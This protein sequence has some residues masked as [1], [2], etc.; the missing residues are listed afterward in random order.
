ML[1]GLTKSAK[2]KSQLNKIFGIEE[3]F[4]IPSFDAETIP[5]GFTPKKTIENKK[6]N[7]E[8]RNSKFILRSDA[9]QDLVFKQIIPMTLIKDSYQNYFVIER[10]EPIKDTRVKGTLSLLIGGHISPVDGYA[11]NFEKC[12]NRHL[13]HDTTFKSLPYYGRSFYGYVKDDKSDLADHI[14]YIY[15]TTVTNC[16]K[17]FLSAKAAAGLTGSWMS[18]EQLMNY[19]DHFDSWCRLI[20]SHLVFGERKDNYLWRAQPQ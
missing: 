15:F 12:L 3:V 19:Y 1:N 4:V 6:I 7:L 13:K 14:G 16:Y 5:N 18:K 20:I 10:E 9:E 2:L 17:S 8:L 11:N